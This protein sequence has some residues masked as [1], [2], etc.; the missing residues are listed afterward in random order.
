MTAR[1]L[2]EDF[3]ATL[4]IHE[5][6]KEKH[7]YNKEIKDCSEPKELLKMKGE[8]HELKTYQMR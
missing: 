8:S 1:E 2:T 3:K 4:K 6:L 5:G 7:K